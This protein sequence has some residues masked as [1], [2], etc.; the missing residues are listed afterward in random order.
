MHVVLCYDMIWYELFMQW[1]DGLLL[2]DGPARAQ[3]AAE[4]PCTWGVP[5]AALLP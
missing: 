2:C 5:R 3:A 1:Y 4:H